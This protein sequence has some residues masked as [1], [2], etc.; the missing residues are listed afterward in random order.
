MVLKW[1]FIGHTGNNYTLF[2]CPGR[3]SCW[4]NRILLRKWCWNGHS[5][6]TLEKLCMF[7]IRVSWETEQ[8][9]S[10][11]SYT[12]GGLEMA[13]HQWHWGRLHVH[14]SGLLGDRTLPV[15]RVLLRRWSWNGPSLVTG[16]LC[17]FIVQVY[18]KTKLFIDDI[19]VLFRRWSWNGHLS[20][21]LGKTLHVHCSRLLD[22]RGLWVDTIV[23]LGKWSWSGCSLVMQEIALHVHCSGV[24]GDRDLRVSRFYSRDSFGVAIH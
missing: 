6:M 21:T 24:L 11:E 19:I 10:T 14:C 8:F 1:P 15:T 4:V 23:L 18:W 20:V 2:K 5:L 9:E 17:T 13:F 3:Q 12:E 22:D 7:M 16:R